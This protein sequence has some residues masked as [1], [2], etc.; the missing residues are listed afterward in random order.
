MSYE[1]KYHAVSIYKNQLF[2]LL[3]G[4]GDLVLRLYGAKT[5]TLKEFSDR[6]GIREEEG[7]TIHEA[8]I[9]GISEDPNLSHVDGKVTITP[10]QDGEVF[11]CSLELH[12]QDHFE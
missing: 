3:L 5:I 7:V 11:I 12:L 1:T 2:D 8:K 10:I 9:R 4:Q 6:H